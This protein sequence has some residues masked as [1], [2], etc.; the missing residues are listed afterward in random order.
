MHVSVHVAPHNGPDSTGQSAR[1]TATLRDSASARSKSASGLQR[2][3][4]DG[5]R[6]QPTRRRRESMN[7]GCVCEVNKTLWADKM[8]RRRA[9][10]RCLHQAVAAGAAARRGHHRCTGTPASL[11][12]RNG[13]PGRNSIDSYHGALAG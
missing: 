8:R 6:G 12:A 10:T 13:P 7:E 1:A 2:S 9:A 5:A 3:M 4:W 11:D